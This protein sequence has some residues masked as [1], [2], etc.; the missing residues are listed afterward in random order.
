MWITTPPLVLLLGY[1]QRTIFSRGLWIS[2]ASIAAWSLLYQNTGWV[3]FGY[4]FSLDYMLFLLLLLAV[5]SRPL[6][7]I[8]RGLVAIAVAINLFGAVTFGRYQQFYR[9]DVSAYRALVRD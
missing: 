9:M 4:R 7:P 8:A 3:Q 6:T 5:D 2:A 1:R